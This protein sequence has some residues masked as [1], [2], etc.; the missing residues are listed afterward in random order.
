MDHS[1]IWT[2]EGK[3]RT[4]LSKYWNRID[5]KYIYIYIY[6]YDIY[7]KNNNNN[8]IQE[9]KNSFFELANDYEKFKGKESLKKNLKSYIKNYPRYWDVALHNLSKLL[10]K[11]KTFK[12]ITW[13]NKIVY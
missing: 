13:S 5:N 6:I 9:E 10:K 1:K 7:E 3:I 12:K 11:D 8:N 2:N 4:V